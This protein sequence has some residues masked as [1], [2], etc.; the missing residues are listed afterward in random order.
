MLEV[1]AGNS[2]LVVDGFNGNESCG[3]FQDSIHKLT[4]TPSQT[5]KTERISGGARDARGMRRQH[6]S[7]C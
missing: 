4:V 5:V 6:R 2:D 1:R 3:G 7:R